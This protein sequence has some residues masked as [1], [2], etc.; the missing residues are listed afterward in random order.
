MQKKIHQKKYN[1]TC[2]VIL[3]L[4]LIAVSN[5]SFAWQHPVHRL[6]VKISF[7]S[8]TKKCRQTFNLND[9]TYGST[10]SD[11]HRHLL[12]NR[13]HKHDRWRIEETYKAALK[14]AHTEPSLADRRIARAFHYILD[15]SEP[16]DRLRDKLDDK[17]KIDSREVGED[18]LL[19]DRTST[20]FLVELSRKKIKYSSYNWSDIL[21]EVTLINANFSKVIRNVLETEMSRDEAFVRV[22]KALAD[23]FISTL[24]LQNH[25]MHRYCVEK[26][27]EIPDSPRYTCNIKDSSSGVGNLCQSWVKESYSSKDIIIVNEDA[28]IAGWRPPR[29]YKK[30]RFN[31]CPIVMQDAQD[32]CTSWMNKGIWMNKGMLYFIQTPPYGGGEI[33]LTPKGVARIRSGGG[34]RHTATPLNKPCDNPSD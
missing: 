21:H 28:W 18:A 3:S 1:K 10:E 14:V 5:T 25:L 31:E 19:R 33:C 34:G 32:G 20:Q 23:Y 11:L 26:S 24:A 29:G 4:I 15:Q 9:L 16:L 13:S 12:I 8:L 27:D 17:W 2:F 6:A 30:H 22:Q 7:D